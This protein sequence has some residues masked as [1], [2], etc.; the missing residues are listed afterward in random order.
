MTKDGHAAD[1]NAIALSSD[2]NETL[3]PPA[4]QLMR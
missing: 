3:S 2:F 1:E 4:G